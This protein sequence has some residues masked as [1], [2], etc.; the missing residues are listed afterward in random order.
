MVLRVLVCA[1]RQERERE[2]I[3]IGKYEIKPSLS[4]D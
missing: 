1:I 2:G 4:E 3:L